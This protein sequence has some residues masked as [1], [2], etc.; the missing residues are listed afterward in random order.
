LAA[1]ANRHVAG[2]LPSPDGTLLA[3]VLWDTPEIDNRGREAELVLVDRNADRIVRSWKLPAG[4][5]DLAWHGDGRSLFVLGAAEPGG[6]AGYGLFRLEVGDG[7][8]ALLSSKLVGCPI[9]LAPAEEPLVSVAEALDSRLVR[10]HGEELV[11]LARVD[12]SLNH[13][14]ASEDGSVVAA[15]RGGPGEPFDVWARPASGGWVRISDLNPHLRRARW[16]RRERLAWRARDG[17]ELDGLLLLPPGTD[18]ADGPFPLV[19]LVHGGP[20]GRFGDDL[21]LGWAFPG[22][23]LAAAGYAVYLPNPR[24]GLGRGLAFA[25]AVRGAV[26]VEDWRDILAG[27]DILL[28]AGIADP[29]R[30][31]IGGWSQGG[32]MS[33]W[34]VTQTDRFRAAVMGAGISDWGMMVA[35]SD[36]PTFEGT[37]GG[38]TGWEGPGPHRHDELSPISFASNVRT[39]TLILHGEKDERV[40]VSQG[41]FFARALRARGAAFEL[42]VYPREPHALGE[43]NHLLDVHR[44]WRAWLERWL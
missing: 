30:L 11:E 28:E 44:R 2:V 13:L 20:Y 7:R 14:S 40:P 43:R 19:T 23:W 38:S 33:A 35:E 17:L 16:A 5:L 24:G 8:L 9:W 39:P 37:L 41:R 31:A 32:F 1:T 21:Q 36:S 3:L 22:E 6:Q 25:S 26:G 18:R 12:G 29:D 34:A 10:V 27:L 42:V 15:V 4:E